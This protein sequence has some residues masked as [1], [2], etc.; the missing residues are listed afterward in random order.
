MQED[1][2][3]SIGASPNRQRQNDVTRLQVWAEDIQ[4]GNLELQKLNGGNQEEVDRPRWGWAEAVQLWHAPCPQNPL[5]LL[6]AMRIEQVKTEA[7]KEQAVTR[8]AAHCQLSNVAH[9]PNAG[10]SN[11]T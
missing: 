9:G 6:A 8:P 5:I 3:C 1:T 2:F 4:T 10:W 7:S 11:W